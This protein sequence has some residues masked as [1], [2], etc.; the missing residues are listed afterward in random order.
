MKFQSR[1]SNLLMGDLV[2]RRGETCTS[3]VEAT[4]KCIMLK[5]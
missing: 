5:V 1:A 3:V 4:E 2:D